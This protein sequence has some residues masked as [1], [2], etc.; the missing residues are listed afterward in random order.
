[1]AGDKGEALVRED[2]LGLALGVG[3]PWTGG[4]EAGVDDPVAEG[5]AA[6]SAALVGEG[7]VVVSVGVGGD[8]GDGALVGFDGF[9]EALE[10]VED[11]AEVEEGQGVVGVGEGGA[12][13]HGLGHEEV[14][15]GV[16]DGA[17]VDT[18]GGVAGV[19]VEDVLVELHGSVAGG[20]I[21]FEADGAEEHVLEGCRCGWFGGSAAAADDA[22]LAFQLEIEGEL[23]G[24]GIYQGSGVTEG[25]AGAAA[26]HA[27]FEK[28][29]GHAGDALH[30]VDRGADAFDGDAGGGLKVAQGSHLR[31]IL[32]GVGLIEWSGG[33]ESGSLPGL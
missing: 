14:A 8:E 30:G 1:M 3:G 32:E 22:E 15:E 16:E 5:S 11:V 18:G 31:Q 10:L 17:E 33:D 29:V 2:F 20:G 6:F 9:G 26:D 12:A 7:E 4:V 19:D 25:E 28:G 23:G 27:G 13:I 24:H 21:F